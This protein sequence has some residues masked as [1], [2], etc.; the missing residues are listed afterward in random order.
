MRAKDFQRTFHGREVAPPGW[1]V[2]MRTEGFGTL[3]TWSQRGLQ[4]PHEDKY[5]AQLAWS[6]PLYGVWAYKEPR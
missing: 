2:S 6:D 5:G 3:Y 1:G 4:R